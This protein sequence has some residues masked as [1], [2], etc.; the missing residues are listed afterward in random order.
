MLP[1]DKSVALTITAVLL[2]G[3]GV[4]SFSQVGHGHGHSA[5][6]FTSNRVS[7]GIVNR[8]LPR[9]NSYSVPSYNNAQGEGE[10]ETP[11]S[12]ALSMGLRSFFSRGKGGNEKEEE[13]ESQEDIK[14]ALEAI[15]ADLEAVAKKE[16]DEKAIKNKYKLNQ[17]ASKVITQKVKVDPVENAVPSPEPISQ[18]RVQNALNKMNLGTAA[19]PTPAPSRYGETVRDRVARVKSGAMTEDEK[20][21]FL[22]N[23]LTPRSA[24]A[25]RG[26]RIR[27]PIPEPGDARKAKL[28]SQSTSALSGD[29]LMKRVLGNA[30]SNERNANRSPYSSQ[31]VVGNDSAK[32][33]YLDMV[34]DPNRFASYAAMNQPS[35]SQNN[36]DEDDNNTNPVIENLKSVSSIDEED[37]LANRLQSAAIIKEQNDAESKAQKDLERKAERDRIAEAQRQAT[38][39]IRRREDEK[40]QKAKAA[41]LKAELEVTTQKEAEANRQNAILAA[42]E[43]YWAKQLGNNGGRDVVMSEEEKERRLQQATRAVESSETRDALRANQRDESQ[44]LQEAAEDDLHERERNADRVEAAAAQVT[45]T[46]PQP[47]LNDVS[48]DGFVREQERKKEALDKLMEEQKARLATLNSPLPSIPED[49]EGAVPPV[50][51]SSPVTPRPIVP[52]TP[53]PTPTPIVSFTPVASPPTVAPPARSPAPRLSLA[54]LTMNNKK[55]PNTSTVR[56][57]AP[58]PAPVSNPIP[59]PVL[60]LREMTMLNNKREASTISR[61]SSSPPRERKGPGPIRQFVPTDDSADDDDEDVDFFEFS[62]N[63]DNKN[64]SLKEIMA[65]SADEDE[66]TPKKSENNSAKQ[67]SKMWGIDIDKF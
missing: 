22:N 23:A 41:K 51:I 42:Q 65:A 37:S 53:A 63:G 55:K 33:Q 25:K 64:M 44:I 4:S 6:C 18:S 50:S 19:N 58:A 34:T 61:P 12:T 35:D 24:P 5:T 28:K 36:G 27:Q 11:S 57:P 49:G 54:E 21:A 30:K 38:F 45:H 62:R 8:D 2:L 59:S 9:Y 16:R 48:P 39:D 47:V 52:L 31:D 10:G 60:S 15:K 32:R 20:L 56:A 17:P 43:D 3:G 40:I 29:S 67:K 13:P 1:V 26:P 14:A 46:V 66:D 7:H